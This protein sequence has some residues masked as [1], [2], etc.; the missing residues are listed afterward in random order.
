MKKIKL[1]A[2]VLALLPLSQAAYSATVANGN[3]S[4]GMASWTAQGNVN[5]NAGYAVLTSAGSGVS[6]GSFGGTNGSIL[7]QAINASA[8]DVISFNYNFVGGDYLPYNDFSLVVGDATNLLA[9]IVGVGAY[10][11]TGWRTFTFTALSNFTN[12]MFLVSNSGDTGYD[13]SLWVDNVTVSGSPS[14]VPVPAA[15][16][17]FGSGIAGLMGM[18]RKKMLVAP[19]I[20]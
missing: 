15:V 3:F 6:T 14:N 9:D 17:L 20:A 13:S 16:W 5:V 1:I 4:S 7:S 18:R 8:G 12:L 11:T 10:G 2:A 19:A